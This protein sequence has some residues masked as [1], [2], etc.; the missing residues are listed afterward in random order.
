M[1]F[2]DIFYEHILRHFDSGDTVW[3]DGSD[4]YQPKFSSDRRIIYISYNECFPS[5]SHL[6][7]GDSHFGGSELSEKAHSCRLAVQDPP[8]M[9]S[10]RFA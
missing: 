3:L 6:L 10:L 1:Y 8:T 2:M 7:N 9:Q 4:L 5:L